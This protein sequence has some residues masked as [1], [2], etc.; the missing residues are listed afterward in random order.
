MLQLNTEF[1]APG[2]LL[3]LRKQAETL[4]SV[5]FLRDSGSRLSQQMVDLGGAVLPTIAPVLSN[6]TYL[7]IGASSFYFLGRQQ[8]YI[9]RLVLVQSVLP[10]LTGL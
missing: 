8:E 4:T 5:H 6:L 1:S 3:A 2:H 9:L 7:G 10:V